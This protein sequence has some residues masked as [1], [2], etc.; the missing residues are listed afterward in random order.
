MSASARMPCRRGRGLAELVRRLAFGAV[1]S[2]SPERFAEEDVSLTAARFFGFTAGPTSP[3]TVD[4][5]SSVKTASAAD[6]F[7]CTSSLLIAL[8]VCW[9]CNV[10]ILAAHHTA[11]RRSALFNKHKNGLGTKIP[12][13]FLSYGHSRRPPCSSGRQDCLPIAITQAS[14]ALASKRRQCPRV[15]A[16]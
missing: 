4:T 16:S 10:L 8:N 14:E 9:S 2:L 1:F 5:A 13:P 3:F 11:A 15:Q 6:A 7:F 12:K